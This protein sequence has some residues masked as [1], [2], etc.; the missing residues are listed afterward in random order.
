[1]KVIFTIVFSLIALLLSAQTWT[2]FTNHKDVRDIVKDQN[3]LWVGTT[4]GLLKWNLAN[5]THVKYTT[6]EGLISNNIRQIAI[7]ENGAVW[8]ATSR[9]ISVLNTAGDFTNYTTED[10]LLYNDI[11]SVIIDSEGNKWFGTKVSYETNG[12]MKLDI[13]GNWTIFN[14]EDILYNTRIERLAIDAN[15]NIWIATHSGVLRFNNDETWSVIATFNQ[16]DPTIYAEIALDKNGEFWGV[17]N[18][19]GIT[20]Y[21]FDGTASHYDESDGVPHYTLS[22]FIDEDDIKWFSSSAGL[23]KMDANNTVTT[24]PYNQEINTIYAE[25]GEILSGTTDDIHIFADGQ[26]ENLISSEGFLSND[27]RDVEID[28]DGNIFFATNLGVPKYSAENEWSEY[29][30]ADG[31]YCDE[32]NALLSTYDNRLI[33]SHLYHCFPLYGISVVDLNTDEGSVIANENFSVSIS[34]HEDIKG[35]I[36]I[37]HY[38]QTSIG[39]NAMKITPQGAFISYD[40]NEALPNDQPNNKTLNIDEDPNGTLYFS[41]RGGGVTIDSDGDQAVFW[42]KPCTASLYDSEANIWIADGD[43]WDY[44]HKLFR[45]DPDGS[46]KEYEI[47]GLS[48]AFKHQIIEDSEKNIWF[49]TDNGLYKRSPDDEFTHYTTADGIADDYVTGIEFS[50]DGA[51]WIS[52]KNGISSSANFATAIINSKPKTESL[53]I[54]PNPSEGIFN[55]NTSEFNGQNVRISAYNQLGQV[56]YKTYNTIAQEVIS[57]DLNNQASGMYFIQLEMGN[58]LFIAKVTKL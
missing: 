30:S 46:I 27:V 1:M 50:E 29:G 58:K 12:L 38:S 4:G 39:A 11:S 56:V 52:T 21:D 57:V 43:F 19:G 13:N 37:G 25:D 36:W 23:S 5:E 31:M 47:E 32:S 49:A 17:N 40:F 34:L 24:Y 15:D 33:I 28:L 48:S 3:T 35:N 42:E 22:I 9:G 51:M 2:T 45:K 16:T 55:I 7:D 20:H 44:G 54:Y 18:Y 8:M 41:T 6:S 10:G 26:W 14:P 53:L